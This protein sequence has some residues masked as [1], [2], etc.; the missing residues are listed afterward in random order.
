MSCDEPVALFS[1]M[2]ESTIVSVIW[3][4]WTRVLSITE[5]NFT[6]GCCACTMS[7]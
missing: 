6:V 7:S 4:L 3:Q 5:V 1:P 2:R